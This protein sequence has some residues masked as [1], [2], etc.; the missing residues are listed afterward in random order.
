VASARFAGLCRKLPVTFALA[1]MDTNVTLQESE[2]QS[3]YF[4][5]GHI[6]AATGRENAF[7]DGDF[8][9]IDDNYGSFQH[10]VCVTQVAFLTPEIA[11]SVQRLLTARY[12]K[13]EVLF[14]LD[15]PSIR[16]TPD[17][18]GITVRASGVKE[19]WSRRRMA[20]AHFGEFR[21]P[22]E[23]AG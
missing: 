12:P 6:L 2:W 21:W 14:S 1:C 18:M 9:I 11:A 15:G 8:W 7:G 13:W 4:E 17:D 5:L 16:P 10:K 23:H 19:F 20:K 3:L 22:T